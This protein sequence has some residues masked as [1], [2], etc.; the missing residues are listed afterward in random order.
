MESES[1][2]SKVDIYYNPSLQCSCGNIR[3][4]EASEIANIIHEIVTA[5]KG[6]KAK[7]KIEVE[8]CSD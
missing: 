4:G 3:V 8:F 5:G 7:L 2:C 1:V 6:T